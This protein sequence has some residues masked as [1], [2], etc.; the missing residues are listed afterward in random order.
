MIEKHALDQ[1][2]T[3]NGENIPRSNSDFLCHFPPK[4]E[5]NK[6]GYSLN[7]SFKVSSVIGV[8]I[9]TLAVGAR[10]FESVS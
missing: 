6:I 7:P 9:T 10:L 4:A 5:C 8:A 1:K 3:T 2:S